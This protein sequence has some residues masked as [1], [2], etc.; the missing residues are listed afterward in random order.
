VT[1]V[2]DM[3]AATEAA[4]EGA[5]R[6]DSD[7]AAATVVDMEV[8][9]DLGT[10]ADTVA[11]IEVELLAAPTQVQVPARVR[12]APPLWSASV[13]PKPQ[14]MLTQQ[15]ERLAI[16]PAVVSAV[17]MPAP[18]PTLALLAAT[19]LVQMP[20]L[21]PTQD[22]LE[23]PPSVMDLAA[24]TLQRMLEQE[25][26]VSVARIYNVLAKTYNKIVALLYL[27]AIMSYIIEFFNKK[28]NNYLS[29]GAAQHKKFVK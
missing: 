19:V 29:R 8:A 5:T 14:L 9:T 6:V 18:A 10:E 2:V 21:T 1:T 12:S 24:P 17:P 3:E 11:D 27:S 13:A 26:L 23:A 25:A 22:R 16:F 15:L 7:T 4:V 20:T 28:F